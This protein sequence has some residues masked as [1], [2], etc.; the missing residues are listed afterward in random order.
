MAKQTISTGSA[1]NDG[2]GDTLRSAG[3]KINSNF[4]EL[5]DRQ[6]A[7]YYDIETLTVNGSISLDVPLTICNKATALALV[8]PNSSTIGLIKVITNKG[9]GIATIS[10]LSFAQGS[11]VAL[12]QYDA[13]TLIWD[14]SKWYITGHYGATVA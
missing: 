3:V 4:T 6:T 14:G 2:T 9:A 10:P 12:D 8:L 11:T 7:P 5:Y 1:A 13:V